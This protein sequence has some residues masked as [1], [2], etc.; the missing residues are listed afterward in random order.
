MTEEI[1]LNIAALMELKLISSYG[2][3]VSNE[4]TRYQTVPHTH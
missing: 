3:P 2:H 1:Y 4:I